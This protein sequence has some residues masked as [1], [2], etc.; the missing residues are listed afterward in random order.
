MLTGTEQQPADTA[1]R[2]VTCHPDELRPH[3]SYIRHKLSVHAYQLSAVAELGDL[4]FREPLIITQ[5][6]TIL[7]GFAR[8]A[9]ARL[10]GRSTLTC[11]EYKMSETEALQNLLQR[12]R[13]STGLNDFI[14]ICLGLELEPFFKSQA[15]EKQQAG[16]R[17]KGSSILTEAERLDVRKE[18]A[19]IAGVSVGNV[20]K[21]KQL[22]TTAHSEVIKALREKE[23]SIHRAWLWSKLSPEEQREKLWLSQSKRGIGKTIRHLLSRYT[24]KSSPSRNAADL[25]KIVSALQSGKLGSVRLVSVNVPGKIILVTDE[26]FQTLEAQEKLALK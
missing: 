8:W 6:H 2:L 15:R 10:Q 22:S 3:P 13:R 20:T 16:G 4:A 9:L 21:V 1:G 7:D 26:L 14:R 11:I 18:I 17:E 24:Q 23:L 5:D 19:R 25:I 12:H